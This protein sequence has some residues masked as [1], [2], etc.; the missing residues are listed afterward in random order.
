MGDEKAQQHTGR[1]G[2]MTQNV[3]NKYILVDANIQM[4]KDTVVPHHILSTH[5][6]FLSLP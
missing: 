4:H 5:P 3:D 6:I 1:Y 2:A